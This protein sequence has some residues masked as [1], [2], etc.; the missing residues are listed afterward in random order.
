[1]LLFCS[2]F[3][4]L[5]LSSKATKTID[6]D[7]RNRLW[8]KNELI[9][10][11]QSFGGALEDNSAA[12]SVAA[13]WPKTKRNLQTDLSCS[14]AKACDSTYQTV[15]YRLCVLQILLEDTAR[16]I[17]LQSITLCGVQN[18]YCPQSFAGDVDKGQVFGYPWWPLWLIRKQTKATQRVRLSHRIPSLSF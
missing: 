5:S 10:R 2:S 4:L 9:N 1:M 12:S 6:S 11:N 17:L 13:E 7:F 8:I 15:G 18:S 14:L 3:T 16:V